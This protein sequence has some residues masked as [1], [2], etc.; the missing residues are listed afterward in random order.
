MRV[1][2]LTRYGGLGASSRLR[3]FQYFDALKAHGFELDD[4]QLINDDELRQRYSSGAYPYLQILFVYWRRIKAMFNT[5][6]SDLL[7][8][9]K[10]AL[11]W[12]PF[13][14]E[15]MLIADRKYV[16]DYDDAVFHSYDL[17]SN[18]FIRKFMSDRIDLLMKHSHLVMCGN[19]Y[20]AA[21]AAN[22][23]ARWVELLPTVIDLNRYQRLRYDGD[24]VVETPRL[25]WIGSP[26]TLVYLKTL[27][28][29][30]ISITNKIPF[31]LRV[32]GASLRIDGVNVECFPWSEQ[33]E[34]GLIS[35]CDIGLMPL[36]ESPWECG[37]CG[38][39]LIQ[40]MA[41]GLAVVASP[42]GVNTQIVRNESNGYLASS[43]QEWT[44]ALKQLLDDSAQRSQMGRIGR[45]M[46]EQTYCTQVSAPKLAQFLQ[47][48][49]QE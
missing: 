32:I 35:E 43:A 2:A 14:I 24:Q 38:Y 33:T 8:I 22:A 1:F 7:W 48:A 5:Q 45:A 3:F 31:V 21:R 4:Q 11:P 36:I 18:F 23:G 39:K 9:E 28:P 42:V 29:V 25:V 41:C 26:T 40:Y 15:K 6:R 16:L 17:S 34:A 10:E 47:S 20:L 30:F 37:K 19:E 44:D 27:I 49:A 13:W 46:V 12:L